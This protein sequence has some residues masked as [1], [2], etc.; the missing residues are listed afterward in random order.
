MPQGVLATHFDSAAGQAVLPPAPA[1]PDGTQCSGRCLMVD[2]SAKSAAAPANSATE[3]ARRTVGCMACRP[4]TAKLHPRRG[5]CGHR[6]IAPPRRPIGAA[7]TSPGSA[8]HPHPGGVFC[9]TPA[10]RSPG[11]RS[12]SVPSSIHRGTAIP[13]PR[14]EPSQQ[15]EFARHSCFA[16]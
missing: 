2:R 13:P 4:A 10:Q 11:K 15:C 3:T 7:G 5:V 6:A 9:A 1:H 16:A 8:R 12:G 14:T